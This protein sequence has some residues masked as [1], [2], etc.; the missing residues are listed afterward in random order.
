[1]T[2][3][4]TMRLA[5]GCIVLIVLPGLFGCKREPDSPSAH[6][7]PEVQ[8]VEI[9]LQTLPDEPE[10]IGQTEASS[11]VEIRPQVTG[12]IKQ[13][14]FAEGRDV[15]QG[16][17][18]YQID[19][20]P[21][22]AAETSAKARV[23]QAEARLVQAKQN[24]ARVKPLLAEQAVSQKDVDDAVAEDLAAKAALEAAR[25][26]LTKARFDLDNTVIVA[27]VDGLIERTRYYEGRLVT[28]QTDLLTVIHQVDPMY[29]IVSAPESFLLKRRRDILAQRIQHPGI[30]RLTGMITFA[31]GT[32]YP[33]EG[34]LDFAGVS[35]RTE[36]GSREARV[37]FPNPDRVLLPG[38][39]VTVRF[40]GVSKPNVV[41][42]PQRAVQQGPK[43]PVVYV[44]GE[45]DKVDIRDVKATLWRGDD[46]LIEEGLLAGER[47]VV[48]GFQRVMPGAH[49]KPLRVMATSPA[50][51]G[52]PAGTTGTEGTE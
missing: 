42:V 17:R 51:E 40:H 25:G 7:I 50:E 48:D 21:F 31:D 8:V 45:G 19:P 29:V 49:V 5:I 15:K 26:D 37:V 3:T 23:G 24:L 20:V 36:T 2:D 47:I 33:H 46:W 10:F 18:L 52:S 44:V 38:Q 39:F 14:F 9:T 13:R 35:L 16:D 32:I 22:K 30:Y 1:M 41:L 6:P 28:A 34:V 11:I 43:G 4:I 12:I 27:P